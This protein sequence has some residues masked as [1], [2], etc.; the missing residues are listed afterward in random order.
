MSDENKPDF[1]KAQQKRME[2]LTGKEVQQ[3]IDNGHLKM[4][5]T[6]NISEWLAAKY[7]IGAAEMELSFRKG[8]AVRPTDEKTSLNSQL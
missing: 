4:A 6:R 7:T 5:Q 3:E 2:T 8:D 1:F